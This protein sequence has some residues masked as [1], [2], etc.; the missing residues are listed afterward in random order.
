VKRIVAYILLCL[1]IKFNV[2][3]GMNLTAV[4]SIVEA[5]DICCTTIVEKTCS[6]EKDT[7]CTEDI[8]HSEE[9]EEDHDCGDES[10]DC[11]CLQCACCHAPMYVS[12]EVDLIHES[13][14]FKTQVF[15]YASPHF[16]ST[17]PDVWQ[18]PRTV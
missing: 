2:L 6:A 17:L 4:F 1:F 14:T 15:Y 18:P 7:C 12:G 5:G 3:T 10:D 11:F 8:D 9:T 13:S 16:F